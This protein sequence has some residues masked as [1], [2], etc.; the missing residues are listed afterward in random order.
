MGLNKEAR[1]R[2]KLRT[3]WAEFFGSYPIHH[4]AHL[5][6]GQYP[7]TEVFDVQLHRFK[8][9]LE[10]KARGPIWG[11]VVPERG[12]RGGRL[13]LHLL[14]GG[15]DRLSND[16][17]LECWKGG[18][19][20]RSQ[21]SRFDPGLHGETYALKDVTP[22]GELQPDVWPH[23]RRSVRRWRRAR[24]REAANTPKIGRS[25][26]NPKDRWESGLAAARPP[27]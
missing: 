3:A 12:P 4:F 23:L 1:D 5:T 25:S 21:V 20:K 8:R 2:L 9:R 7:T 17:I 14:L 6:F 24:A 15:S 11:F 10:N 19:R 22:D 26:V 13:H 18:S 16:E 27:R